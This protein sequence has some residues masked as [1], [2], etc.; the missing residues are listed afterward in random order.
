MSKLDRKTAS[1]DAQAI[2]KRT[3]QL[4]NQLGKLFKLTQKEY[5][6]KESREEKIRKEDEKIETA[7]SKIFARLEEIKSRDEQ[8]KALHEELEVMAHS[9]DAD[10]LQ[11][12]LWV[13]TTSRSTEGSRVRLA[14]RP[15]RELKK[16]YLCANSRSKRNLTKHDRRIRRCKRGTR[17]ALLLVRV[18]LVPLIQRRRSS[19]HWPGCVLVQH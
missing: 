4:D 17:R 6:G 1:M 2:A 3:L 19:S 16:R 9:E 11:S 8:I 18:L 5:E 7:S 10:P 13:A 14:S 12:A 15:R